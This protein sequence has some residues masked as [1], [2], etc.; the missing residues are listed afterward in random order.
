MKNNLFI[1][2]D[3]ETLGLETKDP[4]VQI[5]AVAW[6]PRMDLDLE[7]FTTFETTIRYKSMTCDYGTVAW[8]MQQSENAREHVFN[9]KEAVTLGA[10]L[11]KFCTWCNTRKKEL[12]EHTAYLIA[13]GFDHRLFNYSLENNGFN[14]RLEL[15]Y[16]NW[17]DLRSYERESEWKGWEFD[18]PSVEPK[19]AALSDAVYQ[20]LWFNEYLKKSKLI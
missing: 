6:V 5:G 12:P 14:R 4:I 2:Y 16:K 19:H 10:A 7:H 15:S 11:Y 18:I 13:H 3:L 20:A 8:W 17:I 9:N 1:M